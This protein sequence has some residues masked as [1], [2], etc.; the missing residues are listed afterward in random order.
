MPRKDETIAAPNHVVS[1]LEEIG[2][3]IIETHDI[4]TDVQDGP[5]PRTIAIEY[6]VQ[7]YLEQH[8][9]IFNVSK[10]AET[11]GNRNVT[12]TGSSSNE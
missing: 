3:H 2:R 7:W 10:P 8:S 11:D 9:G 1:N 4:E 12:Y 5:A 6:F